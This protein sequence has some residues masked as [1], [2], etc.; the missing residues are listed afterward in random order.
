MQALL[1][2]LQGLTSKGDL[3]GATGVRWMLSCQELDGSWLLDVS[4]TVVL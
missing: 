2:A 3:G 1:N 4:K